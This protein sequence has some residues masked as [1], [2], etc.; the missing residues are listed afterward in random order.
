MSKTLSNTNIPTDFVVSSL[1][2]KIISRGG[3]GGLNTTGFG[4]GSKTSLSANI[5]N[6]KFIKG[7]L[8]LDNS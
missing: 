2:F 1:T 5:G 3:K 7:T 8:Q 6:Q 4:R